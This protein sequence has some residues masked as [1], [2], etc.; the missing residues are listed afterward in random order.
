MAIQTVGSM[1][2]I[3]N[4]SNVREWAS[5]SNIDASKPLQLADAPQLNRAQGPELGSSFSE[6]LANSIS[7]VNKMQVQANNAME[8][9]A[10]GKSKNL[11]ETMLSVEKAEIAFKTMNQIR[12]KVL[13]AYK[14]VMRMQM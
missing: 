10:S 4:T 11:H 8:R 1:N 7:D 13:D 5:P 6:M 3:L 12:Q 14:E 9:L 2:N